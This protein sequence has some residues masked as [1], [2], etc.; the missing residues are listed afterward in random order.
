MELYVEE[1]MVEGLGEIK[2]LNMPMIELSPIYREAISV[3]IGASVNINSLD[4]DVSELISLISDERFG[5]LRD[6]IFKYMIVNDVNLLK[7]YEAIFTKYGILFEIPLFAL[8]VEVYLG[9]LLK[10]ALQSDSELR[11][12][13]VAMFPKMASILTGFSG[14]Q[15]SEKLQDLK[16]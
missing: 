5:K 7:G 2:F 14:S 1:R 11:K 9:K 13:V 16:K 4:G 15:L 10:Q 6:S 12:A 8:G 3:A